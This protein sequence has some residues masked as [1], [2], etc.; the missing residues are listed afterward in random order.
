VQHLE[1]G[2]IRE[3]LVR[4]GDRVRAGQVLVRLQALAMEADREVLQNQLFTAMAEEARLTAERAGASRIAFPPEL[5]AQQ[6]QLSI[7]SLVGT[8]EQI[9]RSQQAALE[10]ETAVHLRR[11]EQQRA[12]IEALTR[13]MSSTERQTKLLLEELATAEELLAKGY[14]RKPRVL[15]LQR[16]VAQLEAELSGLNGR[17]LTAK[18]TVAESQAQIESLRRQRANAVSADLEKARAKRAEVEEQL[19]KTSDKLARIDV[20][21]P[22]SGIVL[23]MKYFAPGAVVPSGGAILDIVPEGDSLVMYVRVSPLDIDVVREGLAA[24][25]RLVAYKQRTCRRWPAGSPR[26]RP[27][28]SPTRSHRRP[29]SI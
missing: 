23:G 21:A 13:Q 25:V 6:H 14:E 28:P 7:A 19:R 12:S 2:L 9:L 18:E 8:Q 16:N 10:G 27:T 22:Q 3:I 4:E 17:M 15:G 1:G 26:S 29:R 5:L 20:V 11:I 24:E